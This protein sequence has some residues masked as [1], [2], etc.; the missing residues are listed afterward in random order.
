MEHGQPKQ[1]KTEKSE[2]YKTKLGI[3]M[4][5]IFTPIYLSF[6][7]VSVLSPSFM[8]ADVGKIQRSHSVRVWHYY[9]G[10]GSVSHLQLYL[11]MER[12]RG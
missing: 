7:L 2:A 9:S 1:W 4:F 11:F 6:I 3:I 5:A 10:G 12:K 8:A